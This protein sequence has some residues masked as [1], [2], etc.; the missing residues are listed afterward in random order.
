M[1][2][3]VEHHEEVGV[4]DNK[5]SGEHLAAT[6]QQFRDTFRHELFVELPRIE[7]FARLALDRPERYE[8]EQAVAKKFLLL[9]VPTRVQWLTAALSFLDF[10]P[11]ED[12]YVFIVG[13]FSTQDTIV[14]RLIGNS[15]FL[16]KRGAWMWL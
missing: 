9:N 10:A 7:T 13:D 6:E 12:R 14:K 5:E 2:R 8:G 11:V 16:G 3:L 4:I 15:G 1:D